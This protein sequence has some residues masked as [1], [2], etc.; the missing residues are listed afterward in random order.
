MTCIV[1]NAEG[2]FLATKRA[3]T[4]KVYPNKWTVP[5]G[6]LEPSDYADVPKTTADAWYQVVESALRREV[7]EE[8]NVEIGKPEF[9]LDLIFIRPD[10]I[11]VLT[12]SYYALYKG[13]DVVLE[14]GDATEFRWVTAEEAKQLDFIEGIAEEIEMVD[15]ILKGNPNPL[16]EIR[17]G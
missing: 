3:P 2:K 5:G 13:G 15:E 11:P 10:G 16:F 1:Y 12:L 6:G 17:K 9:L 14:E 8:V 7:K 4:K